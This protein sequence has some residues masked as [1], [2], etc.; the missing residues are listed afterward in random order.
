MIIKCIEG[1][2]FL[3]NSYILVDEDTN[4]GII[5]DPGEQVEE[6]L[7]EIK[8]TGIKVDKIVN[9]HAHIDHVAG[10]EEIKQ[11]LGIPFYIHPKEQ[12]VLDLLPESARRF[13]QFGYVKVPEVDG[14]LEEGDIVKIGNLDARVLHVPG[15]TWGSICLVFEGGVISGDTLFAGSVGR[16]DLTGGSSMEEL[17][18]NIKK[19]LLTLPDSYRVFPGHGPETTIG[20]EKRTNPFLRSSGLIL[21]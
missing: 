9:T 8:R 11:T 19:K 20:I 4:S 12:P 6:I 17:V 7:K 15:H 5:I 3:T 1:G 13:P 2:I 18:G 16:V 21:F 14:Y 10:V